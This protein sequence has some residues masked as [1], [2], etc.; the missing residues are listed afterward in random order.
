MLTL[1]QARIWLA[2]GDRPGQKLPSNATWL[3]E[4]FGGRLWVPDG[5]GTWHSEDNRDHATLP[6]LRARFDLQE[7]A[8]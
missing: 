5:R 8:R 4:L 6:E 3:R 7:V 1:D 2:A